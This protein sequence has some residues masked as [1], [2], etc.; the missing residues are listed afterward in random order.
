Y[1]PT[2]PELDVYALL[3]GQLAAARKEF[4]DFYGKAVSAF[5]D[6]TKGKG[7]VQIMT[8]K[9]PEEPGR[10]EPPEPDED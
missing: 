5:N 8:V 9:E 2:Q 1:P 4:D 3:S 10:E 6:A 7:Y